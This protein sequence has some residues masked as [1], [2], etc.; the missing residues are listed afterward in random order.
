MKRIL[1]KSVYD[2]FDYVMDHYSPAGVDKQT[3][4]DDTYAIISIQDSIH[5]GFGFSFCENAFYKGVLTL[6]FDDIVMPVDGAVLFTEEDAMRIISFVQTHKDVESL[7]VHCYAGQ[8]RSRAVAAFCTK[9][10]TGKDSKYLGKTNYNT[11]VYDVLSR[12]W[13]ESS[14]EK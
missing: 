2:A 6:C 7:V 9:L 1:L 11:F 5:G 3:Q 10:L 8:S 4:Q 13:A 14:K 12:T